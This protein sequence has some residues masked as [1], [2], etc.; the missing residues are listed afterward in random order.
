MLASQLF[1]SRWKKHLRALAPAGQA[2]AVRDK[3]GRLVTKSLDILRVWRDYVEVLGRETPTDGSTP[4]NDDFARRVTTGEVRGGPG[5]QQGAPVIP[6]LDKP[7]EWEEVHAVFRQLKLG[8][9]SGPD[10]V[11]AELLLE[12]GIGAELAFTAL[13]NFL[14]SHMVWP[15]G[16]TE[17]I[18]IPL[19]KGKG[20]R[21]LP[22]NFRLIAIVSVAAKAFE[23]VLDKRLRAWG[24]RVGLLSDL[25]GGFR[26]RRST[27]DQMFILFEAI[28]LAREQ[29]QALFLTFIDVRKAYDRVWR[30]G[31]WCKL[32]DKGLPPRLR[33]MIQRM[34]ERLLRRVMIQ[35]ELSGAA[36]VEAGVPQGAVLSPLLY[37]IY[38]DGLHDALRSK[39]LGI[40]L[41]G[42]LV[43]LLMY[44][45]DIVLLAPDADTTRR[46]HDVVTEYAANW[47]FVV[48]NTKSNLMVI[49]SRQVRRAASQERWAMCA[50]RKSP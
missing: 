45:D 23:K 6:E 13:Y 24:E 12:A 3:E 22:S 37:A 15:E 9:A 30:T 35:G 4:F 17:G 44:A 32:G 14:W 50:A 28:A 38:V 27:L 46:M 18:L 10:G 29:R 41:C 42:R 31:L 5:A 40:W 33:G 43:P 48:N 39:G 11:P 26:E 19:F 34:F 7:I 1:W 49:G 8:K 25:Q 16:W 47:R 20:S 36:S 21:Q 2:E